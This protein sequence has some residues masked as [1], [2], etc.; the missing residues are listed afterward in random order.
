MKLYILQRLAYL[1][2]LVLCSTYRL[3]FMF[4]KEILYSDKKYCFAVW[5]ENLF[6]MIASM[7]GVSFATMASNNHDGSIIDYVIRKLGFYTSRGSVNKGG[8]SGIAQLA[9]LMQSRHCHSALAVDGPRGPRQQ[10]KAGIF[11]V[12]QDADTHIIP[13]F[14]IASRYWEFKS[15][16]RFKLPKPFAKI[17]VDI[18]SPLIPPAEIFALQKQALNKEMQKLEQ[19]MHQ[20]R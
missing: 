15:W 4:E 9:E 13:I 3:Q 12:A 1:L 7:R 14:F 16:D 17:Y 11:K 8:V 19:S 18:G 5:H 10:A 20:M 2:T 6:M